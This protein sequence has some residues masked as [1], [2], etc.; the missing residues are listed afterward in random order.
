MACDRNPGGTNCCPAA[1]TVRIWSLEELLRYRSLYR[2]KASL[3]TQHAALNEGRRQTT[4][5]CQVLRSCHTLWLPFFDII[6]RIESRLRP[7]RSDHPL[8][9]TANSYQHVHPPQPSSDIFPFFSLFSPFSPLSSSESDT[10]VVQGVV[11]LLISP[12]IAHVPPQAAPS[13]HAEDAGF[14]IIGTDEGAVEGD[15]W[16]VPFRGPRCEGED[17]GDHRSAMIRARRMVDD[18][19]SW[20]L[21]LEQKIAVQI[22]EIKKRKVRRTLIYERTFG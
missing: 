9:H 15:W 11:D 16:D 12:L 19:W 20:A 22:N 2:P 1:V 13:N 21:R 18:S 8:H 14:R 10:I 3:P 5:S 6:S 17:G 7:C 4:C